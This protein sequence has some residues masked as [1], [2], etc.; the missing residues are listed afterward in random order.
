MELKQTFYEKEMAKRLKIPT[1][2][3][4]VLTID[5]IKHHF[6]GKKVIDVLVIPKR[7]EF[8]L[9]C[10]ES[11]NDFTVLTGEKA[12]KKFS[13]LSKS[14]LIHDTLDMLV[15]C[16]LSLYILHSFFYVFES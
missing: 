8:T 10:D 3:M 5:E 11:P 2:D 4:Y 1:K 9:V 16:I 15:N 7:K 6:L 12:R 14:P 13:S